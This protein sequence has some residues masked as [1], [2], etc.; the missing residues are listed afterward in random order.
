MPDRRSNF[1]N[2]V[3]KVKADAKNDAEQLVRELKQMTAAE[4]LRLPAKT[5]ALLTAAQYREVVAT[6]APEVS[7][8]DP[9]PPERVRKEATTLRDW[10]R[11]CPT[12]AQMILVTAAVTTIFLFAAI[13]TPW[14]WK[15]TMSRV[16]IVRPRSTATWPACARLSR[17][18]D[19]CVYYPVQDL[20]WATA[21]EQLQMSPQELHDVNPHLPPQFVPARAPLAIW[22]HQ[23]H[24][25][26]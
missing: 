18:T 23:G 4:F 17:F 5:H 6:I 21:A 14:A 1:L 22:R 25:E 12:I 7:L 26:D 9:P 2:N 19:G 24:L 8:P 11:A 3:A 15:W 20:D 10:W 16:E 13:G